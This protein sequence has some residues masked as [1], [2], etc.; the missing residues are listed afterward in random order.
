VLLQ[1]LDLF[2]SQCSEIPIGTLICNEYKG[3]WQGSAQIFS[4]GVQQGG[5]RFPIDTSI[6]HMI[7]DRKA[8][9]NKLP[10]FSKARKMQRRYT[11]HRNPYSKASIPHERGRNK[12]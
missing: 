1:S 5:T 9:L 11:N 12:I 6:I 4:I 10:I 3:I 7:H 2:K 8:I